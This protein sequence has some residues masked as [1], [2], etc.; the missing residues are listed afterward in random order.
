MLT[1]NDDISQMFDSE[2]TKKDYE[3]RVAHA[4]VNGNF[5]MLPCR[6]CNWHWWCHYVHAMAPSIIQIVQLH[7]I[8]YLNHKI[9]RVKTYN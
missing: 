5:N 2:K 4:F 1:E 9:T 7:E 3:D 6:G 8:L